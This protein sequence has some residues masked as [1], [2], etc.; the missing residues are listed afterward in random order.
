VKIV[1][2]LEVPQ[3]KSVVSTQAV[4]YTFTNAKLPFRAVYDAAFVGLP[5]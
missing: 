3:M 5:E 4:A 1:S 2:E